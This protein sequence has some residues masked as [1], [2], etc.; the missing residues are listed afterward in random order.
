MDTFPAHERLIGLSEDR[1]GDSTVYNSGVSY[2]C[3]KCGAST[4]F[5]ADVKSSRASLNEKF[6]RVMGPLKPYEQDYCDFD[7][8]GCGV[9][10]RC[11]YALSEVSMNHYEYYPETI[12]VGASGDIPVGEMGED[13]SRK[14]PGCVSMNK[15]GCICL[16]V[17]IAGLV[18]SLIA[19]F[20]GA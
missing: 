2:R 16:V 20:S 10:V 5:D 15:P 4:T 7:C 19:I 12:Y 13:L 11:V 3:G 8:S 9:P 6:D 14:K 1:G 18:A 17:G